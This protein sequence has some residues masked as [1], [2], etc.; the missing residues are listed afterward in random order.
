MS[1][2]ELIWWIGLFIFGML[3]FEQAIRQLSG[4]TIKRVL[5]HYTNKVRKGVTMGIGMTALVQSSTIV[6][7]IV[8]GF[9]GAGI[10]SLHNAMSV[11][12]WA[13][14]GSTFTPWMVALLGFKTDI[15]S[16]AFYFIGAGGLWLLF[17]NEYSKV[18]AFRKLI[19]GFGI[20]FLGLNFLKESV[21][22]ITTQVDITQFA[23]IGLWSAI[24]I[25]LV[26]AFVMQT[27][28]ATSVVL[29][30]ALQ[31][32]LISFDLAVHIMIWANLWSAFS[33]ALM[34]SLSSSG[35]SIV[36]KQLMIGHVIF[37]IFCTI[38]VVVFLPWIIKLIWVIVSNWDPIIS[39][40]LF[41]TFFNLSW[42]I[43]LSPLI[44][45]Y[46]RRITRVLPDR[47]KWVSLQIYQ[48]VTT[49]PEEVLVALGN[50]VGVLRNK[51]HAFIESCFGFHEKR[52]EEE[53][54]DHFNDAPWWKRV[55]E[56][57]VN[58]KIESTEPIIQYHPDSLQH[59]IKE[60]QEIK[61]MEAAL[62]TFILRL[63]KQEFI[64][65][66]VSTLNVIQDR[67]YSLLDAAKII[68]DNMNHIEH[69][70][71]MDDPHIATYWMHLCQGIQ[72]ALSDWVDERPQNQPEEDV[73]A[74]LYSFLQDHALLE[75][76]DDDVLSNQDITEI[77]KTSRQIVY[78][79]SLLSQ[80]KLKQQ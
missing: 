26:M 17:T 20:M 1:W 71:Y 21:V 79:T 67:I 63:P 42:V 32:H 57:F 25:G 45:F 78:V 29:L 4:N 75:D 80:G 76:S 23:H 16:I 69:I 48:V 27:S 11:I 10:L 12:V 68:K 2:G 77:L 50:D 3:Q 66:S 44:G 54:L 24:V 28:A 49:M 36:K 72:Q 60:Y 56:K 74:T 5:Q 35:K 55:W 37:N 34:W 65:W 6:S 30:A 14:L 22:L 58:K 64:N 15:F 59:R 33:T 52:M 39:L 73:D 19:F 62:Y 53:L 7:L 46:T 40:T 38:F 43:L 47:T 51:V 41:H 13:N 8:V 70:A 31:A 18:N 61:V 9:V